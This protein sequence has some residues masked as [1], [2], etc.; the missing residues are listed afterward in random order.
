[1]KVSS[2]TVTDMIGRHVANEH[3]AEFCIVDVRYDVD[4]DVTVY[5]LAEIDEHGQQE[6]DP[7]G[8]V[9]SLKGWTLY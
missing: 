7:G 2:I 5:E 9:M 3:G 6:A 8:G 4:Q 1:M